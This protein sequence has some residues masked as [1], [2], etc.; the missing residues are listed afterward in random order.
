MALVRDL[1]GLEPSVERTATEASG[2][3]PEQ[4]DNQI[5]SA[6]ECRGI[7]PRATS[8][9][10]FDVRRI[11]QGL[12]DPIEPFGQSIQIGGHLETSHRFD[13]ELHGRTN[14]FTATP[15][16]EQQFARK[17]LSH[18]RF[19]RKFPLL[20]FVGQR[21]KKFGWTVRLVEHKK[22]DQFAGDK[23]RHRSMCQDRLDGLFARFDFVVVK[24]LL[25]P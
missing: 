25:E 8:V 23:R 7:D 15:I 11:E 12:A 16:R 19:D 17:D 18:E 14:L 21:G 13:D 10:A 6:Y 20:E 5:R 1:F 9:P 2:R 4:I 22:T 24:K 3:L